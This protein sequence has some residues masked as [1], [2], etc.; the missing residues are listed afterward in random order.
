MRNHPRA[1]EAPSVYHTKKS[2]EAAA[3]EHEF[4]YTNR[5]YG[6][7]N[8]N[9]NSYRSSYNNNRGKLRNSYRGDN[10][11]KN[12]SGKKCYICGKQECWSTRYSRN[13]QKESR[14]RYRSYV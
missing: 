3:N 8:N 6:R 4:F 13:N 7:N 5:R 10:N 12:G 11:S 2:A 9:G 14:H 1:Q